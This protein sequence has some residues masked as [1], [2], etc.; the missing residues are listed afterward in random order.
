MRFRPGL[1]RNYATAPT[2]DLKSAPSGEAGADGYG[3]YSS[4]MAGG[5]DVNPELTGIRKFHVYDEMQKTDPS[6]KSVLHFLGLPVR[7]ARWSLE[8]ADDSPQA[9]VVRDMVAWNLGLEGEDGQLDLSWDELTQQALK[10]LVF[11]AQL[12][13]LV[14]ADKAEEWRDKDGD[15]HLV[16]PL[17]RVAPRQATTIMRVAFVDGVIQ[18]VQQNLPNTRPIP[19]DKLSYICWEREGGRWEGVSLLRPAWGAWFAK[20]NLIIASG[21]AWDRFA[22][23]IPIVYHPDNP[24]AEEKAKSI[25]RNLRQ[26][27]RA[28]VHLPG[29]KGAS[30]WE[31]DLINGQM[32]SPDP[33]LRFFSEQ[34]AEAGM[35]Q[36]TRQGLGQTGARATAEVQ[37]DPYF[38]AVTA[39]AT[40][41][42]RERRRQIIKKLVLVNFGQQAVDTLMPTLTVSRIQSRNLE[43]MAA[44]IADFAMAGIYFTDRG[45]VDDL[46]EELSF[47]ELPDDV[48]LAQLP[49]PPPAQEGDGLGQPAIPPPRPRPQLPAAARP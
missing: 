12:E 26:H 19:G 27:E 31:V 5:P 49:A 37:S 29:P 2:G 13:E 48:G 34:I 6:V 41:I 14:W 38:L 7:S 22:T 36:F 10:C 1:F 32:A 46:R 4:W 24:D 23:A 30:E 15:S 39:L 18:E 11:G 20:K 42:G 8:P 44:A 47:P 43:K 40:M 45:A 9:T 25:G 3:W 35:Q 33:L 21:I 28:Y 17:K 16:V